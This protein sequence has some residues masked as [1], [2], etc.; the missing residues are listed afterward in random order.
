M[1]AGPQGFEPR[2]SG[3]EGL[4]TLSPILPCLEKRR[5]SAL[6]WLGYGP[7]VAGRRRV[8]KDVASLSLGS[9]CFW[10]S[11]LVGCL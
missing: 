4:R 6:S 3:S 10:D 11:L 5:L 2:I 7:N 1:V 9:D 8:L